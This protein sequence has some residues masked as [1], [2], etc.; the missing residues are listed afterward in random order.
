MAEPFIS[1]M[2]IFGF[3]FAP[4]GW[5]TADGQILSTGEH[6]ALFALVGTTYGG[7]GR[8]TFALPNLQG[9]VAVSPGSYVGLN[10]AHTYKWG[11]YGGTSTVTLSPLEMPNHTHDFYATQ[12]I[13]NAPA[14]KVG[15]FQL[16]EGDPTKEGVYAIA[17]DLTT[18]NAGSVD[19]TGGGGSHTNVQPYLGVLFCVSMAGI[20]PSRN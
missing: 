1:E 6:S 9:R 14:N 20:F 4:R 11:E 10:L 16:A 7:D 2:A 5:A 18:L 19:N 12:E 3:N 17:S 8:S 13:G 15:G